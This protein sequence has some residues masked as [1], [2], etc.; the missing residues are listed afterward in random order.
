MKSNKFYRNTLLLLC[1]FSALNLTACTPANNETEGTET[2]EVAIT[3]E[4]QTEPVYY[5]TYEEGQQSVIAL[6]TLAPSDFPPPYAFDEYTM[7]AYENDVFYELIVLELGDIM[8]KSGTYEGIFEPAKFEE[9]GVLQVVAKEKS[10][11]SKNYYKRLKIR[12]EDEHAIY[13]YKRLYWVTSLNTLKSYKTYRIIH[14]TNTVPSTPETDTVAVHNESYR[15]T[16]FDLNTTKFASDKSSLYHDKAYDFEGKE[17]RHIEGYDHEEIPSFSEITTDKRLNAFKIG[18]SSA[19]VFE[20]LGRPNQVKWTLGYMLIYDD[21]RMHMGGFEEEENKTTFYPIVTV[22]Y[23]GDSEIAGL[24]VGMTLKELEAILPPFE[25]YNEEGSELWG[26]YSIPYEAAGFD[27]T[28]LL[29]H[30]FEVAGFYIRLKSEETYTPDY[31]DYQTSAESHFSEALFK[32]DNLQSITDFSE[33][34]DTCYFNASAAQEQNFQTSE[35]G[36]YTYN[37]TMQKPLKINEQPMQYI[38]EFLYQPNPTLITM[39]KD[40][41]RLYTI[42]L[43]TYESKQLSNRSYK[44]HTL[45]R[46][47]FILKEQTSQGDTT[48]DFKENEDLIVTETKQYDLPD[49][50][51]IGLDADAILVGINNDFAFFSSNEDFIK[52][53]L[54]DASVVSSRGEDHFLSRNVY[55]KQDVLYVVYLFEADQMYFEIFR[56]N[57]LDEGK[58]LYSDQT[59]SL[60]LFAVDDVNFY[61][62][63]DKYVQSVNVFDKFWSDFCVYSIDEMAYVN[64]FRSSY[65]Q[66]NTGEIIGEKIVYFGLTGQYQDKEV[67]IETVTPNYESLEVSKQNNLYLFNAI[68][69]ETQFE[70]ITTD[71]I[72]LHVNRMESLFLT[73]M[74]NDDMPIENSGIIKSET[75]GHLEDIHI[76]EGIESGKDILHS[77][78]YDDNR[79]VFNNKDGLYFYDL[80]HSEYHVIQL[81]S[82][83][84]KIYY[85]ETE[86]F[87]YYLD[88]H[89]IF[90]EKVRWQ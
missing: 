77:Q 9:I 20:K 89:R 47:S 81:E 34:L 14:D 59:I 48:N 12:Y 33:G 56:Y 61:F 3:S 16:T 18:D 26:L 36:F 70:V 13:E 15:Y 25:L 65:L 66:N 17:I 72:Y 50:E 43:N 57:F 32:V 64:S 29:D 27:I 4:V 85:D 31:E 8:P 35:P 6:K 28:I 69:D 21:L 10:V 87:V 5:F 60:P 73:S 90:V 55:L 7:R 42:D 63:Y 37:L 22:L 41:G 52:Y 83:Q 49:F 88:D 71:E 40:D 51:S 11:S 38:T 79:I 58:S 62:S 19:V 75:D 23:F 68:N 46:S 78:V 53:N 86:V 45:T 44:E 82:D 54:N 39:G 30:A 2:T 76:I 80:K 1:L 24:K 84:A 74:Y 67:I